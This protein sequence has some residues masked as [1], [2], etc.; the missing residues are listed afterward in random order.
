MDR[1]FGPIVPLREEAMPVRYEFVMRGD[2][3]PEAVPA[4]SDFVRTFEDGYTVLRGTLPTEHELPQVL[5]QFAS[6]GLG[7][8]A[9]RQ[10]P[11]SADDPLKSFPQ[12][13]GRSTSGA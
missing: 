13:D 4:L 9:V 5:G 1:R 12:G 8:H 10:L 7:L 2:L 3:G 11:A 6:L